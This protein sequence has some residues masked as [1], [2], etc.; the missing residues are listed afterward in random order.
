MNIA[1]RF[2]LLVKGSI[3]SLFDSLEDPERSLNQLV[4]D[5]EEQLDQAKRATAQALANE[6]R[7]KARIA[8]QEKEAKDWDKA[9]QGALGRGE[10]ADAREALRRAERAERHAERLR[11]QLAA[12]SQDTE[13]IRESVTRMN[14][15]LGSARERLHVLHARMRQ[16]E[17][18]RAMS[19]VMR[20]VEGAN[21]YGEMERIGERVERRAAE[22]AA[23]LRIGD[24][25]SGDDL[26][27]RFEAAD[28]DGAV[29]ERMA[30]L[31]ER[32]A[33]ETSGGGE[34]ESG[35]TAA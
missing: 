8:H 17:A 35:E 3:T 30:R 33:A 18:R 32:L 34:A 15:Q 27:R 12:Q 22:E 23:Y 7:L 4:L 5:M 25:M 6:E 28:V 10:E 19:K 9:A 11:E 21:L 13:A 1:Q 31:R 14:D 26:K 24:E 29:D 16:S 20:G 2:S